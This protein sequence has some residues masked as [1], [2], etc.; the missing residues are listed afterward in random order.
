MKRM[1]LAVAGLIIAIG[2]SMTFHI[3][4]NAAPVAKAASMSNSNRLI[5]PAASSPS[6][7][8]EGDSRHILAWF[9]FK[10]THC[11]WGDFHQKS[12]DTN[13]HSQPTQYAVT[14]FHN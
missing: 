8:A 6:P 12:E 10:L 11:G 13:E 1:M 3:K 7:V 4:A 9:F 5:D 14:V 2:I